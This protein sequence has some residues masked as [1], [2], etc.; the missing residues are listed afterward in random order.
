MIGFSDLLNIAQKANKMFW[1]RIGYS[2]NAA[3]ASSLSE[4]EEIDQFLAQFPPSCGDQTFEHIYPYDLQPNSESEP[5]VDDAEE[6][7]QEDAEGYKPGVSYTPRSLVQSEGWKE[8][9]MRQIVSRLPGQ[10]RTFISYD[11][12]D[13]NR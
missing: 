2:N 10:R 1:E 4:D 11:P 9:I 7:K 12:Q 13:L 8:Y 3:P 6:I 5:E